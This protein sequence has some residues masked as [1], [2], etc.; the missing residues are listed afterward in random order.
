MGLGSAL[1]TGMAFGAGSAVAHQA[2]GGLF[3]HNYG[4]GM[5]APPMSG[6]GYYSS[7]QP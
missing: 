4:A 2:I 5:G 6:G 3:G 1:A 7:D